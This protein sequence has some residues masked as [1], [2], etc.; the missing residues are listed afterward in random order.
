MLKPVPNKPKLKPVLCDLVLFL[1]VP[2]FLPTVLLIPSF[3]DLEKL[4]LILLAMESLSFSPYVIT[5][6][7]Y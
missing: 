3:I 2:L 7:E 5:I 1:L 4:L 6:W